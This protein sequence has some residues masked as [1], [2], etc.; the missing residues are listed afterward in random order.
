MT[1]DQKV[2]GSNP[3]GRA[4]RM[5]AVKTILVSRRNA[6]RYEYWFTGK[7]TEVLRFEMAY[8]TL[9]TTSINAN[10]EDRIDKT[11]PIPATVGQR[12]PAP[13]QG[14]TGGQA[15][16][17]QNTYVNFLNDPSA[18][19]E[20]KITI[21]GDPD[22]LVQDNASSINELFNEYYGTNG[23]T[24]NCNNGQVFVEVDFKEAIDYDHR[25]GIMSV[26]DKLMFFD[27]PEEYK[28]GPN[29]IQGIAFTVLD[30]ESSFR[31]GKFEQTLK[32]NANIWDT[33]NQRT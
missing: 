18:Y 19:A 5:Q 9:Y 21:L 2:R 32:L 17:S 4:L 16:E 27:Y 15:L 26:N 28:T 14:R 12:A 10:S 1:T 20:A 8:N 13:R 23:F 25:T 6:E 7:N 33:D 31:G 22:W 29:K 24:I 30:V 11:S 3:L